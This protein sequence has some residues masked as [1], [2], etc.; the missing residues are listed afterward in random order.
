MKEKTIYKILI[1][2]TS[3]SIITLTVNELNSLINTESLNGLKKKDPIVCCKTHF[4]LKGT[5][6]RKI[7]NWKRIFTYNVTKR[8][9]Y[10][11]ETKLQKKTKKVII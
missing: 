8:Q 2:S 5:Y 6:R 3:A 1:V 10:L 4:M 9:S 7:K 11:L